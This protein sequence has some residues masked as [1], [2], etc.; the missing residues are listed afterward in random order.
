MRVTQ[1][2]HS[3]NFCLADRLSDNLQCINKCETSVT[4]SFIRQS[5]VTGTIPALQHHSM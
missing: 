2:D 1:F 4:L 3:D 5:P